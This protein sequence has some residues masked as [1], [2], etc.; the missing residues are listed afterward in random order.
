[1]SKNFFEKNSKAV[2]IFVN[3]IGVALLVLV[4]NLPIF[5]DAP[6]TEKYSLYNQLEYNLRCQGKRHII[7]RENSPN[8]NQTR[9]PPYDKAQKYKFDID[10]NG[11]VKPSKIHENPDINIFFIGGSTT[12]CEYVDEPYRFPY[13]A[14]R[15][16]EEKTGKKINSFNAGKSG[17]NSIHSVNNLL[18]K[19]IPLHPD[20]VVRMETI[21][22]LSTLLYEATYWNRNV[23][24]S[25][26]GCFDKKKS[27]LRNFRNEWERSPFRDMIL[28]ENHQQKIKAEHRKIL[29]LFVSITK[30]IGATPVLMTQVNNIVR[31][32]DYVVKENDKKFNQSY[33]KLYAE[34]QDITRQV[35]KENN[36]LLI[37]LSHQVPGISQYIYD[38][39]HLNNEGSKLVSKIIA[40]KLEQTVIN[41][42]KK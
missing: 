5:Q 1:M 12:E 33:R 9:I 40:E 29:T 42:K 15:I 39:V 41:I 3:L 20:I 26:L 25:N 8:T 22:D 7:M 35:A 4:L 21:N 10:E 28:D 38:S 31:N 32:P 11:F 16:L 27:L 37:D 13:L 30:A 17:N 18:N 6:N 24:R 34:F 2:L 23:S 19:I 14:G 36:V